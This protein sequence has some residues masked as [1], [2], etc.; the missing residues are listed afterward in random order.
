V[1]WRRPR[2]GPAASG[3]GGESGCGCDVGNPAGGRRHHP[4]KGGRRD[5]RVVGVRGVGRRVGRERGGPGAGDSAAAWR[6]AA[7]ARPRHA[8]AAT[9]PCYIGGTHA[10]RTRVT[11]KRGQAS[12]RP[13]GQR[14]GGGERERAGRRGADKWGR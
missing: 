11:D 10:A 2:G 3:E 14:R 4:F 5:A 6:R 13:S 12:A 8:R 9:L 1:G 7:A